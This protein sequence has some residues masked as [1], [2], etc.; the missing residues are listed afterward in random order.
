M[1]PI[2]QNFISTSREQQQWHDL[3]HLQAPQEDLEN[4]IG[5]MKRKPFWFLLKLM[6]MTC[7]LLQGLVPLY[8]EN[9]PSSPEFLPLPQKEASL[10]EKQ[11][12]TKAK[13]SNA[14]EPFTQ[15]DAEALFAKAEKELQD[16][17]G[18]DVF[19]VIKSAP[20]E[21]DAYVIDWIKKNI[22]RLNFSFFLELAKRTFR[23][24]RKEGIQWYLVGAL[25]IRY[26]ASRCT[27]PQA[28][29]II[30]WYSWEVPHIADYIDQHPEEAIEP[31]FAA[32][33]WEE[34][35]TS[36]AS[37][38]PVCFYVGNQE[39][40]PESQWES[41][42]KTVR[43]DELERLNKLKQN[44]L[45]KPLGWVLGLAFSPD[46]KY[47]AITD[48]MARM[49]LWEVG[50]KT[51]PR[52]LHTRIPMK[53]V[54]WIKGD[55]HILTV[56][57][58][59][60]NGA[61]WDFQTGKLLHTLDVPQA[62]LDSRRTPS[63]LNENP[64]VSAVSWGIGSLSL[65]P[66]GKTLAMGHHNGWISLWETETFTFF[67][68]IGE[69]HYTLSNTLAFS[70]DS[71]QIAT[72][73]KE[74][75]VQVWDVKSEQKIASKSLE[76][77]EIGQIFFPEAGRLIFRQI[78]TSRMM[79]WDFTNPTAEIKPVWSFIPKHQDIRAST[80]SKSS[81]WLAFHDKSS[82]ETSCSIEVWDVTAQTQKFLLQSEKP[83]FLWWALG[84]PEPVGH[85]DEILKLAFSPD[86]HWLAS[87]GK[88]RKVV[89]WDLQTGSGVDLPFSE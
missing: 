70:L 46:G 88:D 9:P 23:T 29:G 25:R 58:L 69:R 3:L 62:V 81:N 13:L 64:L 44:P 43:Q 48:N 12:S 83:E 76:K 35:Y 17:Y 22:T 41:I 11:S 21:A 39:L 36:T 19:R 14:V 85:R 67:K 56:D 59:A 75:M 86:G 45:W 74:G 2:L 34:T 54:H 71:T 5:T 32:L 55:T 52:I 16:P 47:L 28:R 26:D 27:N 57:Q 30:G 72:G 33:A 8:A 51:S 15:A 87:G 89:L 1:T 4:S 6:L 60:G 49:R 80:W 10:Q 63:E 38:L 78:S 42:H 77:I 82:C 68:L 37:P 84:K 50:N 65:S 66:D 73:N 40:L 18:R 31:G 20:P 79:Q 61:V 24:N 7:F 53:S